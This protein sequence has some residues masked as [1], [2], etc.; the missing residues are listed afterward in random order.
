MPLGEPDYSRPY[1][2]PCNQSLTAA[3]SNP[4]TCILPHPRN[5]GLCPV[6]GLAVQA[7]DPLISFADSS[8]ELNVSPRNWMTNFRKA[9]HWQFYRDCRLS[10][11]DNLQEG[12][13]LSLLL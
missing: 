5:A 10:S 11:V 4:F 3:R 7:I 13:R 12:I 1:A 2:T 9:R 8:G 6:L